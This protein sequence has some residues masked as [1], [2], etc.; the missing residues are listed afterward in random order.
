MAGAEVTAAQSG[1]GVAPA[2]VRASSMSG[3]HGWLPAV[4]PKTANRVRAR[5]ADLAAALELAGAELVDSAPDVTIA[6]WGEPVSGDAPTTIVVVVAPDTTPRGRVVRIA[7]RFLHAAR[8]RLLARR[9]WTQLR[10]HGYETEILY[11]D[12]G[13]RVELPGVT[14]DG[15]TLSG[16]IARYALVVGR[17]QAA[18]TVVEAAVEAAAAR[19]EG[20]LRMSW[21]SIRAGVVVV[22]GD[23]ALL[24]VAIGRGQAQIANQAAALA[25]LDDGDVPASVSKRLP[26]VLARGRIGLA[27]WSLERLLP[28]ARPP[29]RISEPLLAD[30]VDFLVA[31]HGVESG[32]TG[33]RTLRE[34]AAGV[35]EVS[36]PAAEKLLEGLVARLEQELAELPRGYGHG[37]FFAGNLLADGERLTGVVDWDS[38]GPG[39]MPLVDLLHLQLTRMHGGSDE[40]WGRGV[41]ERLLPFAQAGGDDAVQR[42]C[43]AIG[44]VPEPDLLQLLAAA[45]WL[46]YAAY[47]LRTHRIRRAQPQWIRGNVELVLEHFGRGALLGSRSSGSN[48]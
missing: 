47:Q 43:R 42:Y 9:A 16:R 8:A 17:R 33:G 2:A 48:A 46:E 26:L 35:A 21:A 27:E 10:R 7:R 12:L 20:R 28:G 5:D 22:A 23:G 41:T 45:Y 6:N 34:L 24:R 39:R 19:A 40:E 25:A 15:T 38:S 37:D 14:A 4:M 1:S 3:N 30:C 11:W 13:D 18:E 36:S 32:R 29:R 31:L 44:L